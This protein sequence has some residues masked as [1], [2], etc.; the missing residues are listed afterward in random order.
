MLLRA[1][2]KMAIG[3]RFGDGKLILAARTDV[4]GLCNV[5]AQNASIYAVLAMREVADE[6]MRAGR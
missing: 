1:I 6:K 3:L 5:F 4:V 2:I